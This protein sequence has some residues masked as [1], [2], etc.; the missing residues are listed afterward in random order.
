MLEVGNRGRVLPFRKDCGLK[1]DRKEEQRGGG[2]DG[3][4]P[5]APT[6]FGKH[7]TVQKIRGLGEN[8]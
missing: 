6:G 5:T 3:A 4:E 2:S 8:L 7:E 1:S